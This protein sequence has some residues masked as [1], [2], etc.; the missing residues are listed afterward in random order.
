M[1]F[2]R[3]EP[4]LPWEIM[5]SL[6][7]ETFKYLWVELLLFCCCWPEAC[8]GREVA[9]KS[10]L[11]RYIFFFPKE[12]KFQELDGFRWKT[13]Q[14]CSRENRGPYQHFWTPVP[15]FSPPADCSGPDAHFP[16]LYDIL[17]V[18]MKSPKAALLF[19]MKYNEKFSSPSLSW[20]MQLVA[21]ALASSATEYFP[22]GR[23]FYWTVLIDSNDFWP[24]E[25]LLQ[26]LENLGTFS[27]G[28][29]YP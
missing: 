8:V 15:A 21:T 28:T 10:G 13:K 20:H 26:H 12:G 17:E 27:P 18:K 2:S 5:S 25:D 14:E 9:F 11:L 6:S 3:P 24:S 1:K 19:D 16:L 4:V 7:L 29:L 22:R 23:T